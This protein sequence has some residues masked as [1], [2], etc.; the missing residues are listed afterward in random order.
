MQIIADDLGLHP[1]INEG[2]VELLRMGKINGASLVANGEAFSDALAHLGTEEKKKI[3]WHL[4][5]VEEKSVCLMSEISSLVN[6][7][8]FLIKNH[9]QFFIRYLQDRIKLAEV[10]KELR[11]QLN[12]I[13]AA[14]LNPSFLNGH[15]H[16]H[17]L[18]G[19]LEIV[20]RLAKENG[21]SCIRTVS[22]PLNQRGRLFRKIEALFLA[23]LSWRAKRKIK[24]AGLTTND[25]TVGFINAG[26]LQKT[27]LNFARGLSG[28]Y[29]DKT[30]ELICHPGKEDGELRKQYQHWQYRWQSEFFCLKD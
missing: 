22:E 13:K 25:L 4:A 20:I 5:L 27:D 15:Q 18:P 19:I 24:N 10:E 17:L 30:I 12:K 14:G 23:G 1:K 2:I 9:Q 3:G 21:I 16:L 26:H 11:A 29:P 28:K 7:E 8:G 6:E